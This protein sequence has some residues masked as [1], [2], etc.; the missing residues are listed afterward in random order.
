M[1]PAST[2]VPSRSHRCS[3]TFGV[4]PDVRWSRLG[5]Q[6]CIRLSGF[7]P[8]GRVRV[9]PATTHAR[10]LTA[11][12]GSLTSEGRDL[13]FVPKF[14]FVEGTTYRV[15]IDGETV[16]LLT[17]PR[18]QRQRT[19]EVTAIYPSAPQVPR[20]LL[21]L[22]VAFSAP[23]SEG[24]L[25]VGHVRILADSGAELTGAL[26]PMERELWDAEHRRMTVLLDP[27]RIKRGLIAN[28]QISYPL[29]TGSAFSLVV[30]EDWRDATGAMLCGP[31]ER[32]FVV[33]DDERRR[34]DP[35][36]WELS[37][38]GLETRDPLRVNFDR[39][40]D[41]ALVIRCL[42]VLDPHGR[43]VDGEGCVGVAEGSWQF[44]PS[45]PWCNGLHLLRVD[46]VLED[47][48][49]NSVA[50]VFDRDLSASED[51]PSIGEATRPFW[52]R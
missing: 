8:H 10:T 25:G 23:M 15:E 41:H 14:A 46:P 31:A 45:R 51:D 40:L 48:A 36:Q 1:T 49:G 17:R 19:T 13:C 35:E 28:R 2:C 24:G 47:L 9:Q 30:A 33:G 18:P 38:P 29:H 6:D 11:T 34:V 50:R 12:A 32:R 44:T 43:R 21:R 3:A 5:D 37:A 42:R 16:G 52:P 4:A 26:L 20:N 27:A 7:D 22:Y 39:P